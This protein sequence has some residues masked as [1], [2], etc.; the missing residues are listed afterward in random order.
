MKKRFYGALTAVLLVI[1]V[2]VLAG[3]SAKTSR[4]TFSIN[5]TR[6]TEQVSDVLKRLA[7]GPPD[8]NFPNDLSW[9]IAY[10]ITYNENDLI[11][12]VQGRKV[13]WGQESIEV[14]ETNIGVRRKLWLQTVAYP[15]RKYLFTK[16]D[17]V[18]NILYLRLSDTVVPGVKNIG[19]IILV[20][21]TISED[22][23]PQKERWISWNKK[24]WRNWKNL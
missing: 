15:G 12:Q 13:T 9:G 17:S 5:G 7:L 23:R 2:G 24:P 18:G 1:V 19:E 21:T 14:D 6:P 8:T 10:R 11:Y 3:P 16:P 4:L 20:S 22:S